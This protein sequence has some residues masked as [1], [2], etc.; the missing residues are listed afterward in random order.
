MRQ[1]AH[2]QPLPCPKWYVRCP[3]CLA[4]GREAARA[5]RPCALSR[6]LDGVDVEDRRFCSR[7]RRLQPKEHRWPVLHERQASSCQLG[8]CSRCPIPGG[9]A[10]RLSWRRRS[11]SAHTC[12]FTLDAPSS[13]IRSRRRSTPPAGA[14]VHLDVEPNPPS[15]ATRRCNLPRRCTRSF[16]LGQSP[17][18]PRSPGQHGLPHPDRRLSHHGFNFERI[19]S[20]IHAH[21]QPS[22]RPIARP[23]CGG[24]LV[25]DLH[26]FHN[27]AKHRVLA[28]QVRRP[29]LLGVRLGLAVV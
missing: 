21:L 29:T 13:S 9:S 19:A 27:V 8:I 14:T 24:Q 6:H 18:F 5:Q 20:P 3:S 23:L 16:G 10:L 12:A 1:P 17:P 4:L 11:S 28:V 15:P 2:I 22:Q 25:Y 26:A 7:F